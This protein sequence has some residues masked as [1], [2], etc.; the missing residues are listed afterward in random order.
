MM[1]PPVKSDDFPEVVFDKKKIVLTTGRS[2]REGELPVI[3]GPPLCQVLG[4]INFPNRNSD[5]ADT[6][7]IVESKP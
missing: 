6:P 5:E 4:F 7:V 3:I 2:Y 1:F